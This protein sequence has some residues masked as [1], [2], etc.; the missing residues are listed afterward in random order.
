MSTHW[1]RHE[2]DFRNTASAKF[3]YRK[4]GDSG[5]ARTIR[6]MEVMCAVSEANEHSLHLMAPHDMGWLAEELA[7]SVEDLQHTLELFA[8]TG[9]ITLGQT[10][11]HQVIGMPGLVTRSLVHVDTAAKQPRA[12]G[13]FAR[14]NTLAEM[15]PPDPRITE[16]QTY[17]YE[18][19][20]VVRQ[21]DG[22]PELVAL[23]TLDEIK[24][25]LSDYME[26]LDGDEERGLGLFFNGAATV[27]HDGR[28]SR[29]AREK[30]SRRQ[31]E[32]QRKKS[33]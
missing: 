25:D 16:L 14:R 31:F 23:F 17:I 22:M 28:K 4:L 12:R 30:E 10:D 8:E 21:P 24:A 15:E 9:F 20:H 32:E 6:L 19:W 26:H 33:G 13:R 7:C 1:F 11:G 18:Q 3:I 2:S 5:F 29:E 27:V